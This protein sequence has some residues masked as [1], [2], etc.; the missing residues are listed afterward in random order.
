MEDVREGIMTREISSQEKLKAE[1]ESRRLKDIKEAF[2]RVKDISG[3]FLD[4]EPGSHRSKKS[5]R[6]YREGLLGD[7]DER[8]PEDKIKDGDK[9]TIEDMS[10]GKFYTR[11][12]VEKFKRFED[13]EKAIRRAS[14]AIEER[15]DISPPTPNYV[16]IRPD[17]RLYN[18]DEEFRKKKIREI[19]RYVIE[20]GE[21]LFRPEKSGT[22]IDDNE[23]PW[24]VGEEVYSMGLK[25]AEKLAYEGNLTVDEM[26]KTIEI[27]ADEETRE[28]FYDC[29][30]KRSKYEASEKIDSL[31]RKANIPYQSDEDR[32]EKIDKAR[33][34]AEKYDIDLEKRVLNKG[35]DGLKRA[36]RKDYEDLSL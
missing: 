32:L 13:L 18:P 12:E 29:L 20:D 4:G 36:I 9:I 23:M 19:A 24:D 21:H 34:Q 30:E 6:L 25:G 28:M 2:E 17:V 3:D 26:M 31:I 16:D 14:G 1:M 27:A 5:I 8:V 7:D 11:K 22:N 10:E 33:R 15:R 35:A